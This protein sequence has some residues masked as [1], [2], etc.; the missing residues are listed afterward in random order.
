[1]EIKIQ[2]NILVNERINGEEEYG[3]EFQI[4]VP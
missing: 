2:I 3:G 1:M 4:L